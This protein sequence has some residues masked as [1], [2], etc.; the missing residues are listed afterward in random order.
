MTYRGTYPR[1]VDILGTP[2][3]PAQS[4]F[5]ANYMQVDVMDVD[6]TSELDPHLTTNGMV[7]K[8]LIFGQ[9]ASLDINGLYNL[10]KSGLTS[11]VTMATTGGAAPTQT[12]TMTIDGTDFGVI[13]GF[14]NPEFG[15]LNLSITLDGE[16][17]TTNL[18]FAN[19]HPKPPKRETIMQKIGPRA[20][21][22]KFNPQPVNINHHS[23]LNT[24]F[25][26][27]A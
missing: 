12:M 11:N 4:L 5:D 16:G 24:Q 22:G 19:R 7:Q 3:A 25:I 20:T 26:P 1:Q 15:L 10:L 18:E 27:W 9:S 21:Q 13:S 6:A 17:M 8:F 23:G 2:P 14:I